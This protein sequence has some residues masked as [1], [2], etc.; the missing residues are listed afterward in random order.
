M[1]CPECGREY[2]GH[3]ALSRKDNATY[4]C[5]ECG[6]REALVSIGIISRDEQDRVIALTR[7]RN[8]DETDTAGDDV[9]KKTV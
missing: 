7:G 8:G 3:P 2:V 5:P 6:Q 9:S 1:R 4:I